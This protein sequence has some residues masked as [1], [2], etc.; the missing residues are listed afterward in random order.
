MSL[1]ILGSYVLSVA[2]L[3]TVVAGWHSMNTVKFRKQSKVGYPNAYVT[4]AEAKE[5]KD[6]YL[7]NCAQR[8]HAN[9]LEKQPQVLV[10]L[11]IGGVRCRPLFNNGSHYGLMELTSLA[12]QIRSSVRLWEQRG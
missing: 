5:S 4:D 7:F 11:L 1:L 8:A 6:K 3:S 9:Y 12:R 10:G 2:S